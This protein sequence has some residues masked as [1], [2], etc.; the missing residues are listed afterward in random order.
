MDLKLVTWE[1]S[2]VL[3]QNCCRIAD[4]MVSSRVLLMKVPGQI[5]IAE[6]RVWEHGFACGRSL[7]DF[8]SFFAL[9]GGGNLERK[10]A[11]LDQ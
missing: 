8:K 4:L 7:A 3:G 6:A 1:A 11:S 5:I 10:N 9:S 2:F